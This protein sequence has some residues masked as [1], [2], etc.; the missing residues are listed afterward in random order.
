MCHKIATLQNYQSL[1]KFFIYI[2][3]FLNLTTNV[4]CQTLTKSKKLPKVYI[5]EPK[6]NT[7]YLD[8]F[9]T[10]F[11]LTSPKLED[12]LIVETSQGEIYNGIFG[13]ESYNL[14]IDSL[15][16]LLIKVYL[17]KNNRKQ[18][19]GQRSFKVDL[20]DEQKT[21]NSL[22]TKPNISLGQYERGRIP[23]DSIKKINCFS[24][25]ARYKL[26]SS[27]ICFSGANENGCSSLISLKSTC[28]DKD[29]A[30]LWKKI[31]VGTNITF[32]RVEIM[33]LQTKRK[34]ILPDIYYFV[35]ENP[36]AN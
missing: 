27:S 36:K 4:F 6:Q 35:T 3:I 21:L 31:N 25:N 20:S 32:L 18:Y 26:L 29:F 24:I 8:K 19:L 5:G 28:F 23:I 17:F 16:K 1:L 11:I 22:K 12:S 30:D 2:P 34:Y 15:G 13:K 33:D 10:I 9:N 7:L 14:R